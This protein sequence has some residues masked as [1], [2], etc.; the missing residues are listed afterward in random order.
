MYDTT[1][2]EKDLDKLGIILSE[3]QINQFLTY[4]EMLVEWNEVMNLTAI[5]VPQGVA[6]KHFADCLSFFNC[7]EV[8]QGSR[9][10]DVGTGA[11]FPHHGG[12]SRHGY[13]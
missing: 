9:V 4:Y 1:Q 3:A 13:G 12:R 11:G 2:F 5:T 6:V 7:I 10:I 8:E